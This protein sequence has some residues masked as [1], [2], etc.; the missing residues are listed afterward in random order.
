MTVR[1]LTAFILIV[2]VLYGLHEAWPLISGPQLSLSS[3]Q[4]GESFD[5]NFITISGTAVHTQ[6]VS[7][8]D[9]PLLIDQKGHFES[10]L[11]LPSGGAI[12]TISGTDRFGRT[13]SEQRTIFVR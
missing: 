12:L 8:D 1:F 2:V 5:T 11:T 3:P 13:V 4:N 6:A 10:T 9:G 7:L